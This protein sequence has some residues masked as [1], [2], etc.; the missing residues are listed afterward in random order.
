MR[1]AEELIGKIVVIRSNMSGVWFGV[2]TAAEGESRLLKDARRA[3]SWEGAAS[4]SGLATTGPEG[5]RICEP[6][7]IALIG[8]VCETLLATDEAVKRWYAIEAWVS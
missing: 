5:G 4:C 6:V 8:D 1:I 3:W 2:L 7:E